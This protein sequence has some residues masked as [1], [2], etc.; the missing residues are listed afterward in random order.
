MR[1]VLDEVFGS[2]NFIAEMQWERTKTARGDSGG[3]NTITD[4]I[5]GYKKS[6]SFRSNRLDRDEEVAR[7]YSNPDGDP[8]GDWQSV[9]PLAPG[10]QERGYFAAIQHPFTGEYVYPSRTTH[11][12]FGP[13]K[14]LEIMQ[15]WG[16]YVFS[17]PTS[18]DIE[19]RASMMGIPRE[20]VRTDMLNIVLEKFGS[21]SV[22]AA[23][24]VYEK[25]PWP[26]IFTSP[27]RSA[28]RYKTY[29]SRVALPTA[30]NLLLSSDVGGNATAKREIQRLFPD[31]NPFSTPKP[32][33]LLE[34]I[35]H[36]ATDPGDIVLDVF[37]GSGT[38]AAVAHKMARRWIAVELV[39]DTVE[40][41]TKPRLVKVVKNQ[42]QGG[43]TL[44]KGDRVD[45]STEGLAE[46][47]TPEDA[48]QFTLVLNKIIKEHDDLKND[49]AI[50]KLKDLSKTRKLKDIV[51]W[52]GGGSFSVAHLSPPCFDYDPELDLITLTEA[53]SGQTLVNSVAAN[54]NFRLTPEHRYFHGVRGLMRLV[55][56]EG[57][58]DK[59]K[60][61]DL[62][63][64]LKE[65][66]GLTIA[67]TEIEDGVRQYLRSLG[68]GCRAVHIPNDI[69]PYRVGKEN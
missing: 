16:D 35:I 28:L 62:V 44:T 11:W 33:R 14:M 50:K 69:F 21:E 25:G 48:Q 40:R 27:S 12:R 13:S 15:G 9:S 30:K 67:A 34:R 49:P 60:V 56:I 46:G 4:T 52:R 22:E 57:R 8:H 29:A 39:R 32:E 64:H 68:R 38:S 19:K 36:I 51:N 58:L 66:E 37:A 53:A 61:G 54:L 7:L 6:A 1:L 31:E 20:D 42:D 45:N 10:A 63:A 55:V 41:F 18:E 2:G 47:V 43:V 5:V 59:A 17:V 26:E 3:V 24:S 65:D 23:M